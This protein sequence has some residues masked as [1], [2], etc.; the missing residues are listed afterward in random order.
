MEKIMRIFLLGLFWLVLS[1][2]AI[3]LPSWWI[4]NH[5]VSP[6]FGLPGLSFFESTGLLIYVW[7]AG[8]GAVKMKFEFN[9]E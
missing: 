9:S 6:I 2:F 8:N 4:W 5:L 7:L 3:W 1:F